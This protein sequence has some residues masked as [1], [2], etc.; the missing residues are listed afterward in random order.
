[1]CI[2]GFGRTVCN[3]V[4]HV[5]V[6]VVAAVVVDRDDDWPLFLVVQI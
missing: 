6:V 3:Q 4:N 2:E 1:M 5:V